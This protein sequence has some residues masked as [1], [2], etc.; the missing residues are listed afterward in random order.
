MSSHI[1]NR[2][3]VSFESLGIRCSAWLYRPEGIERAPLVILAHG[4]GSIREMRLDAYAERFSQAGFAA[5]VFDYR[6]FG[7]SEGNPR[8]LL[9]IK[10]QRQDWHAALRYARSLSFI[11][12]ERIALFG[13]SF[14]GGHVIKVGAEDGGVAAVISQCPFTSGPASVRALGIMSML[15]SGTIAIIDQLMAWVGFKPLLVPLV[16]TPGT[17]ALMTAPDVVK[18][19]LTLLPPGTTFSAQLSRLYKLF[20]SKR[21]ELPAHVSLGDFEEQEKTTRFVGSMRLPTGTH[22][23]NG[24]AGRFALRIGLDVPGKYMRHLK[25][26]ALICVSS[27]DSVAPAGPTIDFAKGLPNVD[28]RVYDAGHFDIYVGEF[29]ETI[30]KD[31]VSF[32]CD[33]LL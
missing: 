11:D 17:P 12:T 30:V 22:S 2:T 27:K 18:G 23:A 33:K 10:R 31:Q 7:S 15:G 5:L 28:V 16:G 9:D 8:Y 32:L 25:C 13:T 3:D 1:F 24:V 6:H 19:I 20:A 29:F 26:P 14:S 4:L 21:I